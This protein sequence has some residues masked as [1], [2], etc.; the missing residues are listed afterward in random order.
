M[1]RPTQTTIAREN[2][3]VIAKNMHFFQANEFFC[4]CNLH[5]KNKPASQAGRRPFLDATPPIDK[6]HHFRKIAV[7]FELMVKF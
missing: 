5:Y 6:I 7:T 2:I 4:L 1:S 3:F